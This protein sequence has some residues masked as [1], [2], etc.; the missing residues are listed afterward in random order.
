M[1]YHSSSGAPEAASKPRLLGELPWL[2]NWQATSFCDWRASFGTSSVGLA[3]KFAEL[4]ALTAGGSAGRFRC[5]P[6][7]APWPGAD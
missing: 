2:D 4:T 5:V 6:A 7:D 1:E 3:S